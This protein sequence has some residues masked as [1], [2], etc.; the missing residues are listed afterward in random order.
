MKRSQ[1]NESISIHR[2]VQDVIRYLIDGSLEDVGELLTTFDVEQRT[3]RY[4]IEQATKVIQNAY[5]WSL[6]S[7]WRQ[8]DSY[9]PHADSC[10]RYAREYAV[11]SETL[12]KLKRAV[13][14]HAIN[15]GDFKR[16]EE[17]YFEAKCI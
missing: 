4:W 5:P 11:A 13:G 14:S 12:S 6:P 2:V 16:A 15:C 9:N 1:Q 7:T 17:L 8:C 3:P 10:M